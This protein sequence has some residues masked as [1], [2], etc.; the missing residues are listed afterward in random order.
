MAWLQSIYKIA[1]A[2][3]CS[4]AA[5]RDDIKLEG[6]RRE[7]KVRQFQ[8][9]KRDLTSVDAPAGWGHACFRNMNA[10]NFMQ[11]AS[12]YGCPLL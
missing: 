5:M 1:K 8:K 12:N 2:L 3:D 11:T 7:D 9:G 6:D 4:A 10:R